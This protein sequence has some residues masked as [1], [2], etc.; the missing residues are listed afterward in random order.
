MDDFVLASRAYAQLMLE[1]PGYV[2]A[3]YRRWLSDIRAAGRARWPT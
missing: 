1:N 3:G 2:S